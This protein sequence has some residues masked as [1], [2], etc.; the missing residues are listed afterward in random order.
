MFT[1]TTLS[2]ALCLSIFSFSAFS[3]DYEDIQ[4]SLQ[5]PEGLVAEMHG[6]DKDS[7][8]F[9]VVARN[10]DNFFDYIQIP[11]VA[12]Y[13]RE[14]HDQIKAKLYELHRHD[15][16]RLH[17]EIHGWVE[18]A[19]RHI[20]ISK[21]EVVKKYDGGYGD[22]PDYRREAE[23]PKDLENKTSA[24]FKVH[25]VISNGQIMVVEYR[26]VNLPVIVTRPDL[27]KS[28]YRGDKIEMK[29]EIARS[30][31]RPTHIVLSSSDD[32]VTVLDSIVSQHDQPIELCGPLVMFPKSPMV[33]FNVFAI[34]TDIGDDLFRTYTLVNF[35]DM[36]LFTQLREKA[37]EAW[38]TKANNAIRGRNY[39]INNELIACARGP[40]NM[41]DPTQANPQILINRIEDLWFQ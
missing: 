18:A 33:K 15:I 37:Q 36:D 14:D 19:Q 11:L 2:L 38:D 30:P 12:N 29:F 28:L 20:L 26:D 9:V 16:V 1:K 34:K 39:Y 6:V 7:G 10:P 4:K 32:A 40:V 8:F 35:E 27:V 24:V 17:G 41:I 3:L 5:S 31:K 21:V 13:L 22:H 25:A 23:L